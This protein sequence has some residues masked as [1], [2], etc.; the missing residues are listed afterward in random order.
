MH[1][2]KKEPPM[3]FNYRLGNKSL[4]QI[5]NEKDI[6]M[7]IDNHLN[8][9][10]QVSEK[11]NKANSMAAVIRRSFQN[12]NKD[13]FLPLYKALVRSHLDYASSVWYPYKEYQI[14]QIEG[15]QRRATKQL[16]GM[17]ELTYQER[18]KIL[19]L[20]TLK[21][22]RYRGDMIQVFKII[23][24][25]YDSN[26][27]NFMKMRNDHTTRDRGRG[28]TK[29]LFQQRPIH[30]NREFSFSVRVAKIWNS[31]PEHVVNAKSINAFKNR[32]DKHWKNQEVLYNFKSDLM[33]GISRIQGHNSTLEPDEEDPEG[34]VPGNHH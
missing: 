31:L 19:K 1:I 24:G 17:K 26:V 34:P 9:D 28:H 18:L 20:P 4:E 6:G 22:R 2:G 5:K 32:L 10:K 16:P 21:Y 30:Q 29:Q 27:T 25:Y 3:D 8:F 11:V 23:C 15:V 13:I 12:L 14:E 7:I 33:T